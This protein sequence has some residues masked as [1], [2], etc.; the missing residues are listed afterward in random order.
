[1]KIRLKGFWISFAALFS[2]WLILPAPEAI[3]DRKNYSIASESLIPADPHLERV[4]DPHLDGEAADPYL[5]RTVPSG[6]PEGLTWEREEAPSLKMLFERHERFTYSVR[7][8]F[9][10][11]GEIEV[12]LLPDTTYE[13]ERV[14][15]MK[16]VMRSTTRIPLLRNREYHYQNFFTYDDSTMIS[17][18]FWRDDVHEEEFYASEVRFDRARGEVLFFEH[19]ELADTLELEEPASGGDIIFYYGRSYAG[20]DATYR[21]PVYIE[22]DMG[23]VEVVNTPDTE[24]RE[25]DAF[26]NDIV[27]YITEGT[28]DIDGP[29]GFR[30]RFRAWFATDDLRLPVEAHVRILLGNVKVRLISY[31]QLGPRAG[32]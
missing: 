7:Y 4:A 1:M 22:N 16:T 2:A 23:W 18:Y 28:A 31:E 30:G 11:I 15:H 8:G 32:H 9:I 27:T 25:Y 6:G 24:E 21:L 3:P 10:T 17:H 5:E 12:E 26:P 13:G 20:E 29:F 14:L 19:G